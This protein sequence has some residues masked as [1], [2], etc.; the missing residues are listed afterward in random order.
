MDF[1]GRGLIRNVKLTKKKAKC[2]ELNIQLPASYNKVC[3]KHGNLFKAEVTNCVQQITS[4]Q[5]NRWKEIS[6]D[7][8]KTMWI[9]LKV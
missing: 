6:E 9:F 8:I 3:G 4:L 7:D 2:R 1:L 5:V